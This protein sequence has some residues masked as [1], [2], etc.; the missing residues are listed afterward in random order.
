M[1]SRIW[2]ILRTLQA[3]LR[4]V[5]IL[6]AIGLV[7]GNWTL[8]TGYWEKWTRPAAEHDHAVAGDEYY[9]PMHPQIVRDKPDKCPICGMPL[10][11]RKTA[12]ATTEEGLPPGVT[13]VQLSPYRVALAGL[14]TWEVQYQPLTKEISTVGFVEF[15]E[16]KMAQITSWVS[17]KSRITKLYVNM[18]GQHVRKGEPLAQLY[19]PEL[20]S[21]AQNLIDASKGNNKN[22][23]KI[24]RDRLLLWGIADDEIDAIVKSG[25]P[26]THLTIRSPIHGHVKKKYVVE[27]QYVDEGAPLFDVVELSTV[28]IEAQIYEDDV[29]FFNPSPLSPPGRGVG[30]E[31]SSAPP[32]LTRPGTKVLAEGLH[33]TATLK[34][35]PNRVFH[36]KL[37]FIQP[38]LDA[39]TRTLKVR[40]DMENPGH[41]LLPGMYASVKISFP[42]ARL[43]VFPRAILEDWQTASAIDLASHGAFPGMPP[44][45]ALEAALRAG[46]RLALVNRGLLLAVPETAVIDTGTRKFVYR[47]AWPGTY[48]AVE[49]QLGPRSGGFYA[50]V[51]GLE[52]GDKVVTAGSFLIDAET[53][54]TSGVASTYFGASGGPRGHSHGVRGDVRPSMADDENAKVKANLAK[55]SR[56]D[57]RLAEAQGFCPILEN[58]LGAMGVPVKVMIQNQPVFLCCGGCV[59]RAQANEDHTLATVKRLATNKTKTVHNHE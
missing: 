35:L 1:I 47:E 24:A 59:A 51:R 50:M 20:V 14:K 41:E 4:F 11:A 13:R 55:L 17:G 16:R 6:A 2:I 19:S 44:F 32:L 22:L 31:G 58:R 36:G 30:G 45:L 34:A 23:E 42:S 53:R 8:L 48:D 25:A 28:W 18:T 3:R 29:A 21:T 9:C 54:L 43:D 49:V 7:I 39:G 12:A 27:G 46:T 10:S 57:Q 52:A 38:H 26:L 15:D 40:F 5:A 33:V 56:V 37:S